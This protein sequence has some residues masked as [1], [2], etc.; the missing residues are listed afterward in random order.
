LRF[1]PRSFLKTAARGLET[2]SKIRSS[3]ITRL[4]AVIFWYAI[5]RVFSRQSN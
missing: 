4:S 1:K 5:W 2:P 3:A